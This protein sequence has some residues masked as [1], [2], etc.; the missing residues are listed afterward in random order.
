MARYISECRL[1]LH[2][3]RVSL[4][5]A[6]TEPFVATWHKNS[7]FKLTI[8]SLW[9]FGLY[10]LV[11]IYRT[12]ARECVRVY[13]CVEFSM[14]LNSETKTRCIV[15]LW[16]LPFDCLSAIPSSNNKF[17]ID[18]IYSE[19]SSSLGVKKI[20][21]WNC[22]VCASHARVSSSKSKLIII[23][24]AVQRERLMRCVVQL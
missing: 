22:E 7:E 19:M 20:S 3:Q 14:Q 2:K 10:E 15:V 11:N 8:I 4:G 1:C 5:H 12:R 9:L 23:C 21:K 24:S 18:F 6:R 17:I 13:V 16:N